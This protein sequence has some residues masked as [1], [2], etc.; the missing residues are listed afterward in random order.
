MGRRVWVSQCNQ[1]LEPSSCSCSPWLVRHQQ[2]FSLYVCARGWHGFQSATGGGGLTLIPETSCLTGTCRALDKKASFHPVPSFAPVP[3][4]PQP[5]VH[6]SGP[7]PAE[8]RKLWRRKCPSRPPCRLSNSFRVPVRG[9]RAGCVACGP[10][11][12]LAGRQWEQTGGNRD[13]RPIPL[14]KCSPYGSTVFLPGRAV[15]RLVPTKHEDSSPLGHG[16]RS[17]RARRRGSH[18]TCYMC[19]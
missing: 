9:L 5:R 8:T 10:P 4:N 6:V 2:S 13:S 18:P 3:R 7:L 12:R 16:R 14:G 11:V 15:L 1:G 17:F 19:R